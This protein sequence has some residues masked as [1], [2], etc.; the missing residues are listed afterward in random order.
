MPEHAL[1]C[2]QGRLWLSRAHTVK[3]ML[4]KYSV[5]LG[6]NEAEIVFTGAEL[7]PEDFDALADYVAIFKKQHERKLKAEE[8]Q[9]K[10]D[11]I[12]PEPPLE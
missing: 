12:L 6:A 9:K 10:A 3:K 5:P 7:H 1:V 4:A 8:I 11:A 2:L